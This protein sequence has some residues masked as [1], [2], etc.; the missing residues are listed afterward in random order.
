MWFGMTIMLLNMI[1]TAL[2]PI[3]KLPIFG[4]IAIALLLIDILILIPRFTTMVLAIMPSL[5]KP[6][7]RLALAQLR[8]APK[9]ITMNLATII[10]NVS[11]IISI[12]IIMSSFQQSLD[13]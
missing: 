3:T 1:T 12:T 6:W 4:Y 13:T 7:A 10:T 8:G 11:L 2:P 5:P 9:Q